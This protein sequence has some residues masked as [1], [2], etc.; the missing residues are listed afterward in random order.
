MP[1]ASARLDAGTLSGCALVVAVPALLPFGNLLHVPLALLAIS[2]CIAFAR[3]PR[4]LARDPALRTLAILFAALWLPMLL[5]LPDA[6]NPQRS[7]ATALPYLLFLPAAAGIVFVLRRPRAAAIVVTGIAIVL[8]IL[9]ADALIQAA[10]GRN[11]LGYPWQGGV[12][13]GMFEPRQRLGLVLAALAPF[14]FAAVRR[15]PPGWRTAAVAVALVALGT[16]LALSL[17]RSAWIMIALA[18]GGWCWLLVRSG[19]TVGRGRLAWGMAVAVLLAVVLVAQSPALRGRLAWTAGLASGEFAAM[20]R[21][22]SYR[23]SL[24][25]TGARMFQAHWLN[26][27]GPRG[28]RYVYRQYAPP[29]DFW[30]ATFGRG[31]THPHLMALEIGVETGT[32]G[33]AGAAVFWVILLRRL[34]AIGPG[35]L[36]GAAGLLAVAVAWFPFN[37]HMAFY[38]AWWTAVGWWA[39]AIGVGATEGEPVADRRAGAEPGSA[40]SMTRLS[41]RPH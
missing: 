6:V 12:L 16:V 32:L 5:A 8:G 38:S 1:E 2:G 20:D 24:W 28:Y 40:R 15:L 37:A 29:D 18:A 33:L 23:L 10:T 27:I 25:R 22:S 7:R 30:L 13:K 39:L 4:R 34:R 41:G 31:Q 21:A 26:G 35:T 36:A 3:D 17:K 9:C 14:A 11:L 19:S